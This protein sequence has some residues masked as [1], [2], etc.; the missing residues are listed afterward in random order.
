MWNEKGN[1]PS[2]DSLWS[3]RMC[4][5]LLLQ[6]I[7]T[8]SDERSMKSIEGRPFF[9]SWSGGKDSCLAL[10][11]AIQTGG[12]PECLFT[13]MAENNHTSRSH[14]LSRSLL[15]HQADRLGIPIV[16]R[17]ATWDEYEATFLSEKLELKPA[18]SG[19]S[20]SRPI[21]IGVCVCA[22]PLA[23]DPTILFGNV[24]VTNYSRNS[25]IYNSRH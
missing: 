5:S 1:C 19:T 16:F 25:Q 13:M 10:Y 23:F 4:Y 17:S 3:I 14:G 12:R 9:C 20:T 2:L 18:F 15:E 22:A 6:V 11:H 24:G 8:E 21:V 7:K